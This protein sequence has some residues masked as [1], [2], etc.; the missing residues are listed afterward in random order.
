[1]R[2]SIDLLELLA[3]PECRGSL[4]E[5]EATLHCDACDKTYDIVDGIPQLLP[6]ALAG[7][8]PADPAW[9]T[10]AAALDRL[11]LWRRRTWTGDERA[12][13]LQ[14]MVQNIQA[15]FVRHCRISEARG[16]VL[17]IGCGSARIAA[18]LPAGCRYVGVDPLP[19]STAGNPPMVRG[20]GERLP[21]REKTFDLVLVLETLDHCQSAPV[22]L[23]EI[24]RVL[25]P[26]GVLCVEQYVTRPR[27][28]ERFTNWWQ[29]RTVPGRPAPDDSPKV[30]LLD[31]PD[32]V[33]LVRP[34]FCEVKVARSTQGAHIFMTARGRC[35]IHRT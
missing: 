16:V 34:I 1:M 8:E 13:S 32:V 18:A 33:A 3:C 24:L 29:T 21:F 11:L 15:E 28:R 23:A 30:V 17:D 22:L 19:L 6:A 25:K 27:W 9:Q 5:G 10:W 14:Q 12:A 20:V 7:G 35:T 31:A 2:L 4:E 26:D